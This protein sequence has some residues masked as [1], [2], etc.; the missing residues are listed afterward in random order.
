MEN[1]DQGMIGMQKTKQ[2]NKARAILEAATRVFMAHGFSAAT[3]DMIQAES[4]VSKS[5]LYAYFPSKEA[6]FEAVIQYECESFAAGLRELDIPHGNLEEMLNALGHAYLQII[7]SPEALALFRV[8]VAETPRFPQLAETFYLVGPSAIAQ[9]VR[10]HFRIAQRF[11]IVEFAPDTSESATASFLGLLRSEGQQ[12]CLLNPSYV[13]TESEIHR[14]VY[15]A[16]AFFLRCYK[17]QPEEPS[18]F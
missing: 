10:E 8:V 13:P 1:E 9:I 12:T 17:K 11:G 15:G 5:T 4:G 16:V 18:R 3:T 6:L 2:G 7:L 14:W